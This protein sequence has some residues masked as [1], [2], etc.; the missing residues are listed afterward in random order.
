MEPITPMKQRKPKKQR[1]NAV[2]GGSA[3]LEEPRRRSARRIEPLEKSIKEIHSGLSLPVLMKLV[4]R[5]GMKLSQ[6]KSAWILLREDEADR[7][8]VKM[9]VNAPEILVGKK[10]N[11]GEGPAGRSAQ[12]RKSL[13][14]G[15]GGQDDPL[16]TEASAGPFGMTLSV[17]LIRGE[18][19]VG[20]L[21]LAAEEPDRILPEWMLEE[22]EFFASHAAIALFNARAFQALEALNGELE[23][24]AIEAVRE[25]ESLREEGV[26]KEKLAALGRIVGTVNHELRQPL[27]VITNAVYYL[28][29]QLERNDVGPI[30]KEFERFL[31]IISDECVNMTDLVNELLH[32]TRKKSAVPLGVDLNKLL[33][34]QLQKIQLPAKV[35]VKRRLDPNLPMIHA[36]PVQLSRAFY[37]ILVNGIQAMPKGGTLRV[38]TESSNGSV[39]VSVQDSGVGIPLEHL[40]KI[41]EPLF[42]TKAKGT[43]LG[44]AMVKEY[45]E[46]NRGQIEVQ[47]KEGTGTT[48]RSSFPSM[49]ESK[50]P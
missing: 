27:E 26:R 47:S 41:F 30:K 2:D 33:E 5:Q 46:A 16:F 49:G 32:F 34:S 18:E 7:L 6:T 31:N 24:K 45:I 12:E 8:T 35:K 28:K 38:S 42:T 39:V 4:L 36:D 10:M 15:R 40:K 11:P 50:L 1:E 25:S 20:V 29:M 17:P 22:V 21:C 14:A 19:L 48:F 43:G 44:L 9:V 3:P 13:V 23:R 37:N